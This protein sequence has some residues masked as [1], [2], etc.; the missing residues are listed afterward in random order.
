MRQK[1]IGKEAD[2]G[3]IF[4]LGC[5]ILRGLSCYGLYTLGHSEVILY[6]NTANEC[7]IRQKRTITKI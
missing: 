2:L 4:V 5:V 1:E 3:V 6:K 7:I